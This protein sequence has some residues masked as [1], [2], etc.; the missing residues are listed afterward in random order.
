MATSTRSAKAL[1][2]ALSLPRSYHH[3]ALRQALLD[4]SVNLLRE[5]G[6]E[7]L[8]LRAAARAAGVSQTAPYRHFGD[9]V[10]YRLMC[11]S[12]L[13]REESAAESP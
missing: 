2:G 13:S 10:L 9:H 8:S 6:V 1:K 12:S 5:G 7:A 4:A 11:T 3:G